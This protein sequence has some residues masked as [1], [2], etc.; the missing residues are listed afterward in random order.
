MS[1]ELR[2]PLNAII[3]YSDLIVMGVPA[4]MP[5]QLRGHVERIRTSARHLLRLI[6]E[7]LTY[8]RMEAGHEDLSVEDLDATDVVR[9]VAA[10]I[11]PLVRGKN[12]QLT[13]RLPDSA[14]RLHTDGG[15]LRQILINLMGNAVKFTDRGE[16]GVNF[17]F[18]GNQA[19]FTVWDTGVGIEPEVI[20]RI[21]EAFWQAEQS[22]TRRAEG[23]GLGLT[24]ARR[25]ARLLGGDIEV[26]STPGR[27]S[28]FIV[29]I[30]PSLSVPD[31]KN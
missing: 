14:I 31:S 16:V 9:E 7:I 23:T 4:P 26:E 17:G 19:C 13:L 27:G 24:V 18:E 6:E 1:H 2:T 20:G 28:R 15:K 21:F 8:A 29:R 22:R 5:T 10:L 11:E 25:L 12:L 30:A 3:G